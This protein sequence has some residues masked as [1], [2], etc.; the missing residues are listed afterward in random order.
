MNYN[1]T[2]WIVIVDG[3]HQ[4]MVGKLESEIGV[5]VARKINIVLKIKEAFTNIIDNIF[6]TKTFLGE[7]FPEN[8]SETSRMKTSKTNTQREAFRI[9]SIRRKMK[10]K[11]VLYCISLFNVD[12]KNSK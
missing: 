6:S 4:T 8:P 5:F 9:I 7:C 12:D 1:F 10:P 2:Y 3:F 11:I